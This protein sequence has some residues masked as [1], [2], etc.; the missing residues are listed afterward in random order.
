MLANRIYLIES[1]WYYVHHH[2]HYHHHYHHHG[3]HTI[4]IIT[5][6]PGLNVHTHLQSLGCR[7]QIL[8]EHLSPKIEFSTFSAE[9]EIV[10]VNTVTMRHCKISLWWA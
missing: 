10:I 3:H 2:Q 8:Q 5:I 1:F 7:Q 9:S 4:D 6:S